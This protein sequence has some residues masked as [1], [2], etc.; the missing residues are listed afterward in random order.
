MQL[1]NRIA[2]IL[3]AASVFCAVPQ[4]MAADISVKVDSL[5]NEAVSFI[6]FSVSPVQTDSRTMVPVRDVCE[7][8]GIAVSWSQAAQTATLVL[9]PSADSAK[10]VER[11]AYTL[12]EAVGE[13]CIG[14]APKDIVATLKLNDTNVEIRYNY[15]DDSGEV[16]SIGKN[17]VLDAPVTMVNDSS[18]MMPLRGVM[19]LFGLEVA[20]DQASLTATIVIPQEVSAPFGMSVMAAAPAVSAEVVAQDAPLPSEDLSKGTYLGRFK[21]THYC[22]CSKCN[23]GWGTSTAWAGAI[24][25]GVTI[26]VD[27]DVIPKLSWV[28]IEGYGLRQA[29]DCGGAIKGNHIDMAVS[30]HSEAM[31]LGVVYADVWLQQ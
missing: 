5:V 12:S 22:T 19:E 29:Q 3:A 30:S 25:P 4:V 1:K 23:G 14:V 21:I 31:S 13:R 10:P 20:W 8:A 17:A 6:D 27:P 18:L 24:E 15:I 2:G 28:Y 26:A 11:Y 16:I 7:S 9:E